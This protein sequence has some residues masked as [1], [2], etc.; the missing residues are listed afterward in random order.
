[1][2]PNLFEA[3][4]G[5][6]L[7]LKNRIALSPMT[8]AR[9]L[10]DGTPVPLMALFYAQRSE[11]GLII[12]EGTALSRQAMGFPN[13]PGIFSDAHVTAWRPIAQ[14]LKS[15]GSLFFMQLWHM[16][17]VAHPDNLG[18]GLVPVAPS[19]IRQE[20]TIATRAGM[21][22]VPVPR[23]LDLDEIH[24]TIAD[25][26]HGA[27]RAIEA[28]CDGVEIHAANGYLPSQFL[29][30]SSNHRTD[31]YGGDLAGR[32]RFLLEV[33]R[34][35]V[36]AVGANR[37]AVRLTPFNLL[38]GASSADDRVVYRYVLPALA[39][40]GLA[41]LAVVR[42]EVAGHATVQL[43]QGAKAPD[44]LTF[45]RPLWPGTLVASGDFDFEQAQAAVASGLTDVVAFGR[46]FIANPDLVT[47]MRDRLPL[48]KRLEP[49]LWY[50]NG[51]KGYTDHPR[52]NDLQ[53]CS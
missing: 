9:A 38:N 4:V 50:G 33:T 52:W 37:V 2:M 47:R 25:Y 5:P 7:A 29:H 8:R 22:P 49:E 15:S 20:R 45:V 16:G 40:H 18:P 14:A 30:E 6:R 24:Q 51:A 41:Y 43:P 46:D 26:A 32:A 44:V 31:G 36:D 42:A 35:C 10:D 12:S 27:R 11:A 19:P 28:G 17:R 39:E 23:E 1:M 21:K 13:I 3:Y 34:A 48:A 53:D